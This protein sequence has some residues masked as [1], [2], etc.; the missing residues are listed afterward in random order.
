MT[1]LKITGAITLIAGSGSVLSQINIP[2]I[3]DNF[4]EWPAN[5]ILGFIAFTSLMMHCFLASRTAKANIKSAE[6]Q[7]RVAQALSDTNN[8][9]DELAEKMGRSNEHQAAMV[10]EE[11]LLRKE[12]ERRPCFASQIASES[13][14]EGSS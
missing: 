13:P 4:Q 9:L 11:S 5:A 3:P 7:G 1:G 14:A 6:E 8:R 10:A 2:S 12:M